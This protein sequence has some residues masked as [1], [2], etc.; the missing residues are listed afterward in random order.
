M[1]RSIVLLGL[2]L[3]GC[4]TTSYIKDCVPECPPDYRCVDGDCVYACFEVC[5]E[6]YQCNP[7]TGWCVPIADTSTEPDTLEDPAVD[8]TPDTPVD[9]IVDPGPEDVE[10][11]CDERHLLCDG[12]CID[13]MTDEFNCGECGNVCPMEALCE[14]GECECQPTGTVLCED[15][16]IDLGSDENCSACG[17]ACDGTIGESCIG[18]ACACAAGWMMC[19]GECVDVSL[20]DEHCGTCSVSCG[21]GWGCID[22]T[23]EC[24]VDECSGFCVDTMTNELHC[25]Y[26]G[27]RCSTGRMC[28]G[29]LCLSSCILPYVL[30][31]S[32]CFDLQGGLEFCGS[33]YNECA[34]DEHCVGGV[35][36]PK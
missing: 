29:G 12:D 28:S 5:E 14:W 10:V 7:E 2:V 17:D 20:H 1:G 23:C 36:V 34:G 6:G 19:D 26:C 21:I 27:N 24:L 9:S 30:C 31:G 32:S 25:G 18:G 8:S 4:D 3:L 16:C 22:G 11:E 15:E 13:P 35:C 33:C